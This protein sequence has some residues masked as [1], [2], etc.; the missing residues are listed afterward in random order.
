MA[1]NQINLSYGAIGQGEVVAKGVVHKLGNIIA[2]Y[3][4]LMSARQGYAAKK[5]REATRVFEAFKNF[6]KPAEQQHH[7]RHSARRPQLGH[8]SRQAVEPQG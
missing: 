6:L 1:T 2:N 5:E 4:G 7:P 8:S 3:Y